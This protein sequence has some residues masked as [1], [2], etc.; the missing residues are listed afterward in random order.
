MKAAVV[1]LIEFGD[2]GIEL[3]DQV[4]DFIDKL[5]DAFGNHQHPAILTHRGPAHDTVAYYPG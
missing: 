3:D 5:Q 1:S 2:D 4:L